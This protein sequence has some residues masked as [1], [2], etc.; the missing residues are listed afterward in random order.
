M[1]LFK[2]LV[3]N[4]VL[5]L[6]FVSGICVSL[7]QTNPVSFGA[8]TDEPTHATWLADGPAFKHS[9]K[10]KNDQFCQKAL[11]F[12]GEILLAHA[13]YEDLLA[14]FVSLQLCRL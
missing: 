8:Y 4:S 11:S 14:G 7:P 2:S 3:R 10:P 13:Q 6:C 5:C 9:F 1:R 12:L